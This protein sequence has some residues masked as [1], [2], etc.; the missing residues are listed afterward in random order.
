M[1]N[2]AITLQQLS[3]FERNI[4]PAFDIARSTF[5]MA[6]FRRLSIDFLRP[7]HLIAIFEEC[8]RRATL[9]K[10]TLIPEKHSDLFQLELLYIFNGQ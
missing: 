1:Q 5:Q 9:D 4:T 8:Q 3:I 6:Q 10:A 2:P 7:E